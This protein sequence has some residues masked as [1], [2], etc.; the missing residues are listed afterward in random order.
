MLDD[1]GISAG[2]VGIAR[3]ITDSKAMQLE[4]AEREENY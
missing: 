1:D 3:D 2:L 4:L